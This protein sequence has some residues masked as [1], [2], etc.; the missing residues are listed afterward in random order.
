MTTERNFVTGSNIDLIQKTYFLFL[1]NT[2][3]LWHIILYYPLNYR[4]SLYKL[5]NL[6][7][8]SS[9]G[10]FSLHIQ[11]EN[12]EIKTSV[13]NTKMFYF[14]FKMHYTFFPL[15]YK[16]KASEMCFYIQNLENILP[17]IVKINGTVTAV[18]ICMFHTTF[19]KK[20]STASGDLYKQKIN[21][22]IKNRTSVAW[23]NHYIQCGRNTTT[24]NH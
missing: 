23:Y 13:A 7:Y 6:Y 20:I 17:K 11:N 10:S 15:N 21:E 3:N 9:A 24:N 18:L 14:I 1:P 16:M 8:I 12:S 4:N 2:I 22:Y 5:K 19:I